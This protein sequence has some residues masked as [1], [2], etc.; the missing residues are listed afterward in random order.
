MPKVSKKIQEL[1]SILNRL[2]GMLGLGKIQRVEEVWPFLGVNYHSQLG[3]FDSDELTYARLK[4][5]RDFVLKLAEEDALETKTQKIETKYDEFYLTEDFVLESTIYKGYLDRKELLNL[6]APWR[7]WDYWDRIETPKQKC[8][9]TYFQEEAAR[10]IYYKITALG[11]TGIQLRANTGDGKTY[12]LGRIIRKIL[13]DPSQWHKNKSFSPYKIVYIT[14]ASIV[15]QTK[16][17][18]AKEF[19]INFIEDDVLVTNYDQ[20]RAALGKEFII[21]KET[22]EDGVIVKK[23]MWNSLMTPAI[24]FFDENQAQKNEDSLQSKYS[25][26]LNDVPIQYRPI[27]VFSSASPF[28]KIASAKCFV[29]ATRIKFKH[30]L[31]E[32]E[33]TPQTWRMFADRFKTEN[34]KIE[35]WD[36]P[37]MKRLLKFM[38]NYIVGFKNVRRKFKGNNTIKV[39]EFETPFKRQKYEKAWEEYLKKKDEIEGNKRLKNSE[40]LILVEFLKFRQAAEFL[41]ADTLAKSMWESER[42]GYAPICACNFKPTIAKVVYHLYHDYNIPREKISLIWG[43]SAGFK[44]PKYTKDDIKGIFQRILQGEDVPN[45][46]LREIH[47]QIQAEEY[48]LTDL[49]DSL[50]L[51]IQSREDR[52]TQIQRFQQGHSL[53]CLFTFGAGGAGLSLHHKY[54]YTRQRITFVAPTYNE[55]ELYQAFGRAPRL[56]SLSNTDQ[57]VLLYGGTIEER[58]LDRVAAKTNVLEAVISHTVS[59]DDK[60]TSKILQLAGARCDDDEDD[61]SGGEIFDEYEREKGD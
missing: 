44:K 5:I 9:A 1:K 20:L 15:D 29:L 40:F 28:A 47:Q 55:M 34:T 24:V 17:D 43:G 60:E 31:G 50:D 23:I 16:E 61:E 11:Y 41:R 22:V 42:R 58:V 8:T 27:Q 36:K 49:D 13:D 59:K 6:R 51:G 18:L 25:V 12:C 45:K 54:E 56:T 21:E 10:E 52:W 39:I 38:D 14:K 26:A 46:I 57:A 33:V 3:F 4:Q 35:D 32:S 48:G 19:G 53:Y 30:G 37:G 7:S 2:S